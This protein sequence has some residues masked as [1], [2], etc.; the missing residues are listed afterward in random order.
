MCMCNVYVH[1]H[2]RVLIASS[3][4][5]LDLRQCHQ[6]NS[7]VCISGRHLQRARQPRAW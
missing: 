5:W 7:F 6:E 2:V 3:H 4:H 1:V